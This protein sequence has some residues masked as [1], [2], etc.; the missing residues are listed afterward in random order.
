M[1]TVVG[2]AYPW[3][4]CGAPEFL[5]DLHRL[6]VTRVALAA[7]YH[8]VRAAT[9]R[10]PL[11]RFVTATRSALYTRTDPGV[12]HMS[13]LVP[14]PPGPWSHAGAFEEAAGLLTAAGF[15][16]SA[17]LAP[18]HADGLPE[19]HPLRVQTAF[20]DRLDYALCPTAPEVQ[21]YAARLAH[22]S[23][24]SGASGLVLECVGS[25]GF[26]HASLHDKVGGADWS[27]SIRALLSICFCAACCEQYHTEG[28]APTELSQLLRIAVDT[29]T[30][31]AEEVVPADVMS[32]VWKVRNRSAVML[33]TAAVAAASR[34]PDFTAA[35]HASTELSTTGA[36]T[37][38]IIPGVDTYIAPCWND[39]PELP[40][41]AAAVTQREA[42][43]QVHRL[44]QRIPKEARV[45][46]YV[47]VVGQHAPTTGGLVRDWGAIL[48]A[49][50]D[51]LHLYHAGLASTERLANTAH[52]LAQ[53]R[54]R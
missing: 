24:L 23:M 39:H 29:P 37:S 22:Q 43:A 2:Y 9:P 27:T 20:G 14:P 21:D 45:A 10:H 18:T 31:A 7:Y 36:G 35:L 49:G 53:L 48:E 16:V 34:A 5:S 42:I 12:W 25:L 19:S 30:G 51:E 13:P 3:D 11:H 1:V 41:T 40:H 26:D 32:L 47:T 50:A 15:T 44:R 54:T 4:V 28:I 8:G 33:G 52:A 6:G 17:W 46:S 38:A